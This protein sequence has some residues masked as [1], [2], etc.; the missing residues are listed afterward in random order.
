MRVGGVLVSSRVGLAMASAV[1]MEVPT[2][3]G[4]TVETCFYAVWGP[5]VLSQCRQSHSLWRLQGVSPFPVPT[6]AGAVPL[7]LLLLSSLHLLSLGHM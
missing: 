1:A 3:L 4:S 6:L 7:W 2:D 5:E